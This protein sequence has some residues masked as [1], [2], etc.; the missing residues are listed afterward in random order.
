MLSDHTELLRRMAL[1]DEHTLSQVL[2]GRHDSDM[3]D[4]KTAALVRIAALIA[5]DAGE[6]SYGAAVE[7][8][9]LSGAEDDEILGVALALGP[10]IGAVISDAAI[11]VLRSNTEHE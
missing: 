8:A 9:H 3:L 10:V 2:G 4:E 1:S 7:A 5:M 6:P 11:P